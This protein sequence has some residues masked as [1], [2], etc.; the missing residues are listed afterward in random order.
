MSDWRKHGFQI[1]NPQRVLRASQGMLTIQEHL[2]PLLLYKGVRGFISF[3]LFVYV[4]SFSFFNFVLSHWTMHFWP[5]AWV[6]YTGLT[7]AEV[8]SEILM[9][10]EKIKRAEKCINHWRLRKI[11][12]TK[13]N[14]YYG[15]R[16]HFRLLGQLQNLPIFSI[17]WLH[18]TF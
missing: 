16:K 9:Q 13:V 3:V 14:I 11:F 15:R 1:L 18:S 17:F 12:V 5:L 2:I 8:K 4:L 6:F 7:I 10:T